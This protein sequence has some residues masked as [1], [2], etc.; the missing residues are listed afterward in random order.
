MN[1]RL[2][3]RFYRRDPITLARALLGQILVRHVDDGGRLS[4]R[5]V[6]VEAYLGAPDRAAHSYGGRRTPR[7]ESM[8]LEGGHAYVYFVYGMHWCFN[9]VAEREGVPMAC[10]VRALEPLEGL[11]EMRRRRGGREDTELCSGPAKLTQALAID[12]SLDGTDL[13]TSDELYLV[14][15]KVV[16]PG[17]IESSPRI[18]V[19]YAG[20]WA[21][22]P[23]RFVIRR[24]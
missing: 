3:R 7:N 15:G 14:R 6:E 17:R 12:R 23:L 22:K 2:G 20:E 8:W 10:L 13:V 19:A 5:I 24:S 16:S 1:R 11:E 9:I 18:G 4:G 21:A